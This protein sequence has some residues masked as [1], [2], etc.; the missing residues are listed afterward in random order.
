MNTEEKFDLILTKLEKIEDK[1]DSMSDRM[2]TLESNFETR[3]SLVDD[4]LES[5]ADSATNASLK[6]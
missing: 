3:C 4:I 2:D 6:A 5:K 1:L